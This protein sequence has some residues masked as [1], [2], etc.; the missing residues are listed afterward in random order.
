MELW[1]DVMAGFVPARDGLKILDLGCGTGRYSPHLA[2]RFEAEVFGVEPSDR[3]R[4]AAVRGAAGPNVTYLKGSAEDIPLA[5]ASCDFALLSMVAHHIGDLGLGARELD[6]ILRPGGRIFVRNCFGGRLAGIPYYEFF[7]AARILDDGRLPSVGAVSEAM[8]GAGLKRVAFLTVHQQIDPSLR[9]H[10]ERLK[11]GAIS[12]ME[13][14]TADER[15]AGFA[16]LE[17]AVL[18]EADPSPVIEAIDVLVFE[19]P[20]GT[21]TGK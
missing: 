5:D 17:A 4:E 1:L 2:R 12:T 13:L 21:D 15:T 14:I 18:Q 19:K 16:A 8:A 20:P 6:R 3:M 11:K 9:A 7:P 10:C